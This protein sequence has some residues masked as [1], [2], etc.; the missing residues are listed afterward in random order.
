MLIPIVGQQNESESKAAYQARFCFFSY[1]LLF[2]IDA[3]GGGGGIA[4]T[5]G[6]SHGCTS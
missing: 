5:G 1:N 3:I 2:K 4:A 6:A